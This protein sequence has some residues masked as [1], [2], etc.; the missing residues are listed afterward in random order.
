MG[1][2]A[3]DQQGGQGRQRPAA[4]EAHLEKCLALGFLASAGLSNAC[5]PASRLPP[6]SVLAPRLPSPLPAC[7]QVS[8]IETEKLVEKQVEAELARRKAHGQYAGKFAAI[9]HFFG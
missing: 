5:P 4:R 6:C 1:G 7:P 9:T 8:H 3:G 2:Q